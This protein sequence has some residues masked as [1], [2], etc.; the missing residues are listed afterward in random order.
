MWRCETNSARSSRR[1]D[2]HCFVDC[3]TQITSAHFPYLPLSLLFDITSTYHPPVHNTNRLV[4]HV[5]STLR[6]PEHIQWKRSYNIQYVFSLQG[7][8]AFNGKQV[9]RQV[10]KPP[11]FHIVPCANIKDSPSRPTVHEPAI[12]VLIITEHICMH[13]AI[14]TSAYSLRRHSVDSY[15]CSYNAVH[16]ARSLNTYRVCGKRGACGVVG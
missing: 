15:M 12:N 2:R 8:A 6:S 7:S 3:T 11:V 4:H 9:E 16:G 13:V 14:L 5:S 1:L 10:R